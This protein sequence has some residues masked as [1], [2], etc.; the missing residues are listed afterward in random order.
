MTTTPTWASGVARNTAE[1]EA[2]E[3]WKNLALAWIPTFGPTGFTIRDAGPGRFDGTITSWPITNWNTGFSNPKAPGYSLEWGPSD[4]IGSSLYMSAW[5]PEEF[6]I[7]IWFSRG[8]T[9]LDSRFLSLYG[10][11]TDGNNTYGMFYTGNSNTLSCQIIRN[12][13]FG[14]ALEVP[15]AEFPQDE[16]THIVQTVSASNDLHKVYVNGNQYTDSVGAIGGPYTG[17]PSTFT[18]GIRSTLV[19]WRNRLGPL[20]THSKALNASEV[21]SLYNDPLKMFRVR[22]RNTGAAPVVGG[23]VPYPNPRYALTGGMQPMGGGV[24]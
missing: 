15:Q 16:W 3:L 17:T 1:S 24:V 23:F 6:S 14:K 13:T 11:H 4:T 9:D 8:F 20:T 10:A 19:S 2:P 18:Y 5:D 22:R 12:G 7:S 21:M